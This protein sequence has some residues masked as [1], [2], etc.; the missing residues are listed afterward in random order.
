MLHFLFFY[1][2]ILFKQVLFPFLI[3]LSSTQFLSSQCRVMVW[4][5]DFTKSSEI[6]D[7]IWKFV[8]GDGCPDLCG[9]GNNELQYYTNSEGGNAYIQNGKLVIEATEE[10]ISNRKYAS[11]KLSTEGLKEMLYGT[12]EVRAKVPGG[13]GVWPA[14]WMMPVDR[15]YGAWP[16]CGEIDIMEHVGYDPLNVYGTVH[17]GMYNHLKGTQKGGKLSRPNYETDFHTYKIRWSEER[18]EFFI[19]KVRYYTFAKRSDDIEQW[20]FDQPFYL[21]MNVAI[22]GNWGGAEGISDDIC[23]AKMEVDWVRYYR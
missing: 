2:M 21:I 16:H 1:G 6:N 3:Y 22:G 15:S 5:D 20:P 7:R 4:E 13:V 19:D 8:E 18:I 9:W 23:P 14:V 11:A 12:I 17:T 10:S